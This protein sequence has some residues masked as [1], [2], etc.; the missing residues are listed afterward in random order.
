MCEYPALALLVR[1]KA[2][3]LTPA[4]HAAIQERL[5]GLVVR[6]ESIDPQTPDEFREQHKQLKPELVVFFLS[7]KAEVV[8]V[9]AE[10]KFSNFG[11]L[12]TLA[13]EV[14]ELLIL[15]DETIEKGLPR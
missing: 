9:G 3:E 11:L 6:H 5:P 2:A 8:G 1:K 13:E 10:W 14:P 12:L 4:E 7:R 15:D